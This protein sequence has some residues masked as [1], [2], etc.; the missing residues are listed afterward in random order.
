MDFSTD[1][2]I[3]LGSLL[4]I[5]GVTAAKFSSRLGLPSLVL[6]VIVGLL[7]N[8]FIYF[9]NTQI[10]QVVGILA[11]IIILFDGGMQT[12]WRHIRPVIGVSLSLATIGVLITAL[13]VAVFA[14][15]ILDLTWLESFLFGSIA[16]STDAAAIF[17]VLG[18]KNIKEK[19]TSVLEAESGTNDP[20]AVFLTL[21]FIEM[22]EIGHM[23]FWTLSLTFL[24][25]M[26]LGL[27]MGLILGAVTVLVINKIKLA[28]TGLY[29]VLSMAF[30]IFTYGFTVWLHGSGLL[31]V[32]IMALYVG[33]KELKYHFSI[34]RFNNGIAWLMQILMFILLGLYVFPK[35]LLAILGKGIALSLLL[36]LVARPAAVFISTMFFKL[37]NKE[38]VFISWGGLKGA[39]PIVLATYPLFAEIPKAGYIFDAVFFVVLS[40]ALIQGATMNPLAKR[41][42]LLDEREKAA[43]QSIELLAA[44][45]TSVE[46]IEFDVGKKS[47]L[48]G[49]E[50]SSVG[51]PSE[52]LIS[53]IIRGKDFVI[54][55]G[56]TVIEQK[57]V[58][59]FLVPANKEE[60]LKRFFQEQRA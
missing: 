26:G 51:L 27:L 4:L 25:E 30:A 20:M 29:P 49:K 48:A 59:C 34:T 17:S 33:N 15:F 24:W 43:P 14:K 35:D 55:Q 22:I 57:D 5:S 2:M 1:N 39:V 9:E 41:F 23:N 13:L 42:D 16:G 45:R 31:A 19:L 53:A 56:S 40:S 37:T 8:Q 6:F 58:L 60:E 28:E 18:N 36:M 47:K 7:L 12:N 11:L 54:P 50:I 44:G 52:V 10:T 46:M 21:S 38:R 3:L 32:Y